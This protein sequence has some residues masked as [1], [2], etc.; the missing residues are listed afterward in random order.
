MKTIK[1]IVGILLII[2]SLGSIMSFF[3]QISSYEAPELIGH[4]IAI[5][6]ISWFAYLLLKPSK[7]V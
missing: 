7:I 5:G 4:L 6:L 2:G 1:T 3:N